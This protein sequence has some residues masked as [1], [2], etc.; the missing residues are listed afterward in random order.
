METKARL[1]DISYSLD[2]KQRVT[3]TLSSRVDAS[4]LTDCDLR[5][6]ATKWRNKRSLDANGLL[7]SCLDKIAAVLH[8]D[9]W[10]VYLLMLKRYGQFTYL[11]VPTKAV[12]ATQAMWRESE[13]VGEINVNGRTAT[14]ILC[15]FGSSTYDTKEFS[16][17]LDG[18]ISEMEDMG[19]TTP[20]QE[21]LD[22]VLKAWEAS[23]SSATKNNATS[24]E[25]NTISNGTT[26]S[27]E[28]Q[29]AV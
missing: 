26:A 21:E 10:Q 13:V 27:M 22:R 28:G 4:E 14:Q 7:W 15:Y 1:T 5:L 9:K 3:F 29:I 20:Q 18:V 16:R 24:A 12:E 23:R 19:L 11:I 8:T 6:K 2:G 17:L 25:H